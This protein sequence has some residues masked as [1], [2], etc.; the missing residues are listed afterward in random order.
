MQPIVDS[1]ITVIVFI[2]LA[3]EFVNLL[4]GLPP[5]VFDF[6]TEVFKIVLQFFILTGLV[7]TVSLTPGLVCITLLPKVIII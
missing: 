7:L 2:D 4:F 6:I 5:N 3:F 1:S